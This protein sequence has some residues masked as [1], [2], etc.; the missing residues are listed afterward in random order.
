MIFLRVKNIIFFY[1]IL[2]D[3]YTVYS[4]RNEMNYK[5]ALRLLCSAI[6]YLNM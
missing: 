5:L 2:D 1:F 6:Q 3:L 4:Y